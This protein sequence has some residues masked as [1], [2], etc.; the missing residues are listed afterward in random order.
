M[1][2]VSK[3]FRNTKENFSFGLTWA[4]WRKD[5]CATAVS[6]DRTVD[7]TR[8]YI[9]LATLLALTFC[10]CHKL[11]EWLH[12]RKALKLKKH[13]RKPKSLFRRGFDYLRRL[14][15]NFTT[16]DPV[17]WQQVIKLLS[18]T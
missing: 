7:L 16:F 4:A 10:F 2:K 9:S 1:N 14:I 17:A 18:C 3:R 11:G 6:T 13:G 8:A 5:S 12:E 15:V